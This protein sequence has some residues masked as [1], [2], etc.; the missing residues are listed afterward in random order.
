VTYGRT[1]CFRVE[2]STR[3][4][5]EYIA[6]QDIQAHPKHLGIRGPA[7]FSHLAELFSPS[8][9]LSS[10]ERKCRIVSYSSDIGAILVH[11]IGTV[12]PSMGDVIR[13]GVGTGEG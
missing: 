8:M 9:K 10:G 6:D 13:R 7:T 11:P 5:R 3:S 2:G 12:A 1:I 4:C